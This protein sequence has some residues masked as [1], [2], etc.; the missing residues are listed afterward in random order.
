MSTYQFI[1]AEKANHSVRLMCRVL[2]VARSAFYTWL[3]AVRTPAA[4][5]VLRVH[6]RAIHRRSHGAYGRPRVTQALRNEGFDVGPKRV[7]RIMK[8]EGLSG[9][10]KR[11]FRG[12]TTK[13]DHDSPIAENILNRDFTASSPNEKWVGDITYL[14]TTTGWIYLAVLIDLYSRK[15]IGW[16]ID[17]HMRVELCLRAL[18][19]ATGLRM[20][21]A[22]LIHHSDRG[23]QYAS[24]A[25]TDALD[26]ISAVP[27]MS[28]KGN[29]WDNA[30]AESFF[31][32]LEQELVQG[33]VWSSLE[34]AKKSVSAYI[35]KFF[36]ATR[37][38][39]SN[40]G[41]SPVDFE[42]EFRQSQ[43]GCVD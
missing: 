22:G 40:G 12:S 20:P 1:D 23:S 5:K 43:S 29:C 19:Q 31:G 6:I 3:K 8:E 10:P 38:H 30:V 14:P 11:R 24:I 2:K 35:H 21:A 16:A 7:A 18:R 9:V 34:A 26:A 33:K 4:D 39:S 42:A 28:R 37:F 41:R 15:V 36:N 27:S 17:S 32:T 25:Y 13:S